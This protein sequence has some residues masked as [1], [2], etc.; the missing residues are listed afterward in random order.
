MNKQISLRCSIKSCM[1]CLN[2]LVRQIPDKADRIRNHDVTR[3]AD[4]EP[5]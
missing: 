4:P 2:Q 1:K 5:P 3:L